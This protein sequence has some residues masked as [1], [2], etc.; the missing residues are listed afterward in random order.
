MYAS[1]AKQTEGSSLTKNNKLGS[2]LGGS[3]GNLVEWYDWYAYAAFTLYFS[4]AFFPKD[5][6]LTQQLN[7]AAIF[8]LGFFMRPI[9]GWLLGIYADRYGRKTALTASILLMCAGSLIIALIP[10]YE[11]IGLLA[12]ILLLLARMLQGLS[13][14]G[15]YG[16]SATYLSEMAGHHDRGFW[17]SFQYV[18]LIMGQLA[19]LGVLILLQN[20]LTPEQLTNWG[21]RIPFFIGAGLAVVAMFIRRHME[22]TDAFE[23]SAKF[24]ANRTLTLLRNHPWQ[25]LQVVGL[26]LGGTAAF[27][28][29]T[30]YIQK[31]M[32]GSAGWTK[33]AATLLSA[34]TLFIYMLLQP[35]FGA[36]SDR[37]GRKPLLIGFGVLGLLGTVPIMTALSGTQTF[38]P[39]FVLVMMALIIVSGYTSI[40]A[41]VKAELFP[42]HV[43]ALGVALP[44]AVTV[45]L[46]G[47]SVELVAQWLK[48]IGYESLF[49]WYITGCIGVSLLVYLFT[50]DTKKTSSFYEKE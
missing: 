50:A 8:A 24:A 44:Y 10:T 5:D 33:E 29:Y 22:E 25:A 26:T 47:G 18:T 2:I 37:I 21:W 16:A 48:K 34:A 23:T 49:F 9:G 19:A 28:T 41:V 42:P 6:L 3:I 36:L 20:L 30:T 31:F 39:A 1:A 40:N 7:T 43:R 35:A 46:F 4:S 32:V 14:G 13:V 15:E 27:Y 38:W 12:P 17:S 45:S 11:T